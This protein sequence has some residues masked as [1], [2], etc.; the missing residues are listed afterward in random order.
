VRSATLTF[1]EANSVQLPRPRAVLSE[2]RYDSIVAA[3]STA[4]EN[5]P[6]SLA[7]RL[8]G[9]HTMSGRVAATLGVKGD[10]VGERV[11]IP[12]TLTPHC[13]GGRC[14]VRLSVDDH[15]AVRVRAARDEL[16]ARASFENRCSAG[17]RSI[18]TEIGLTI[19]DGHLRAWSSEA[20]TACGGPSADYLV[21]QGS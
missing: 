6:A 3:P 16:F 17:R 8:A 12:W 18:P 4:T 5:V 1:D 14:T 13:H 19:R 11:S 15:P 2:A 21:W 9:R 20:T 7:H 10:R